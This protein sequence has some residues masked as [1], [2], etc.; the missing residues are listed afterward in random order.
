MAPCTIAPCAAHYCCGLLLCALLISSETARAEKVTLL[1][2]RVLDGL[3]A[4]ITGVAEDQNAGQVGGNA[5]LILMCDN[6]LTR[7]FVPKRMVKLE[8]VDRAAAR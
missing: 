2:G 4:P 6:H 3:L 7:T 5:K 8:N 1:D